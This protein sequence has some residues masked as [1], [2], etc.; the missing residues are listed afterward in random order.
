MKRWEEDRV[1]RDASRSQQPWQTT[2]REAAGVYLEVPEKA[3]R[4]VVS[5]KG[6]NYQ[7]WYCCVV[8]EKSQSCRWQRCFFLR[9]DQIRFEP[10]RTVRRTFAL[11]QNQQ[12]P[13]L[14]CNHSEQQMH[15]M[16]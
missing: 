14:A 13:Y 4:V 1:A 7:T 3:G 9:R 11:L 2:D 6:R 15:L 5:G 8:G 10:G 12:L 16:P